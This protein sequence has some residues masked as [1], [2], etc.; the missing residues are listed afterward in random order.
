[1]KGLLLG[2]KSGLSKEVLQTFIRS[3][4]VHVVVLSGYNVSIIAE[5]MFRIIYFLPTGFRYGVGSVGIVLFAL[6]T[7][8]GAA[9]VRA[10]IMALITIVARYVHRS[11]VAL[12]SLAVAAMLM[13]LWNPPTLLFDPGFVLSML[14]TFGLI[15]LSPFVENHLSRIT[16]RAP[17]LRSIAASTIAVQVFVLPALLYYT[18][19]FSL[20]ALPANILGLPLIPLTMLLGGVTGVVGLVSSSL[21]ALPAFGTQALLWW[22]L[23]VAHYA[24]ALPWGAFVMESFPVWVLV[25][26]YVPLTCAAIAV[27]RKELKR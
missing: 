23:A 12:R 6:M 11:A 7:G 9:T 19:V 15:T 16:Q 27:Y 17:A 10:C 1:M 3:S 2:E 21:A 13:V 26:L 25:L 4:L 8:G 18:G 22:L 24:S 20:V 5:A 14:A